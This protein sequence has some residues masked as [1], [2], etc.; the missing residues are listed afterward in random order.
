MRK[1]IDQAEKLAGGSASG[2]AVAAHLD[3]AARTSGAAADSDLVQ[4][5]HALAGT[6]G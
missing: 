3:N 4:A 6:F 2:D 5:L 1:S